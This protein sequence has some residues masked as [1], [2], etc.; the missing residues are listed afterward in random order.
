M[1]G[2]ADLL[3]GSPELNF[4]VSERI[5]TALRRQTHTDS[6]YPRLRPGDF[7]ELTKALERAV[8]TNGKLLLLGD[9]GP[10]QRL[11]AILVAYARTDVRFYPHELFR[12]RLVHAK[13]RMLRGDFVGARA[14]VAHYLDNPYA[15]EGGFVDLLELFSLDCRLR[16]IEETPQAVAA[17]ARAYA[18]ALARLRPFQSREIVLRLFGFIGLGEPP[19]ANGLRMRAL[20]RACRGLI[21][22]RRGVGVNAWLLQGARALIHFFAAALALA[23][24]GRRRREIASEEVLVTRAMG[25]IG[26]L[27]MMTPGL[28]A[29]ALRRGRPVRFAV[30][31]RFF[32]VLENNPHVDL[33]DIEKTP[34][35]TDPSINW[36]NLSMCPAGAY[37][38]KMRPFVKKSRVELF[39]LGLGVSRAELNRHGWGV[40]AFLDEAQKAAA[41]AFLASRGL[42]GRPLVGV[43]PYSRDSYKDH[44]GIIAFIADLAR[45]YDVIVFHHTEG[46]VPAGPGVATTAG[47]PLSQSVAL[48]ARLS[49]MVSCDS[50]FLHVAGA[51]DV[52]VFALFGPTDGA[53]FT[54]HHRRATVFQNKADFPCS[55][56]WRNEDLP[57]AVTGRIGVSPCVASLPFAP[58]RAALDTSL[59][60]A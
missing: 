49:A 45:D 27:V 41:Q 21:A 3:A 23:A 47:L 1:E 44:P 19:L 17:R 13:A 9:P 42:G 50:A 7:A 53:L 43:Q 33:V 36:R 11:D 6:G 25:G 26:D 2:I 51:F 15:L 32:A 40:E 30:P 60:R 56:C 55:P 29:L 5:L 28:R 59:G 39:A 54:R 35:E 34:F 16:V 48:V 57:C 24:L 52:P 22:A 20:Y 8:E 31:R 38:S 12:A 37:E 4:A 58:I 46:A 18:L 10:A 14:A